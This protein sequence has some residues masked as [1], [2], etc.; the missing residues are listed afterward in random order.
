[1]QQKLT[2]KDL[3]S[4]QLLNDREKEVFKFDEKIF[5]EM[6]S[7]LDDNKFYLGGQVK[8]KYNDEIGLNNIETVYIINKQREIEYGPPCNGFES[9]SIMYSK[10]ALEIVKNMIIKYYEIITLR[11]Q[12]YALREAESLYEL[13]PPSPP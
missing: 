12:E 1:M 8:M 6:R 3:F 13:L 5:A 7:K 4:F 11:E 2:L 10:N 9:T